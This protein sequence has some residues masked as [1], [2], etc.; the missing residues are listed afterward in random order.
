M[1]AAMWC[2][3][4]SAIPWFSSV[5]LLSTCSSAVAQSRGGPQTTAAPLLFRD[6]RLRTNQIGFHPDQLKQVMFAFEKS[7]PAP[8]GG[9]RYLLVRPDLPTQSVYEGLMSDWGIDKDS[10]E[11]VL[12]GDFSAFRIPGTY[13]VLLPD[14]ALSAPFRIAPDAN[15][16]VLR[17]A[18]RWLFLQRSGAAK[19]DALTGLRHQADYTARSPL[20]SAVGRDG[21]I[22][23]T[24]PRVD[25]SGGW[26]DAG[27]FGRYVPSAATTIMS[28]L[29]AY[30]FNPTAF[31]DRTLAIPE[32]GNGVADLLDEIRWELTWL[33]KM[34]R[35]DGAVY[36]KA[37]TRAYA[38]GMA[39]RD[40]NPAL[41]YDVS[42]QATAQ[43]AGAL[44][45]ASIVYRTIDP[46]FGARLQG[47][48]E[49]AWQ[50]LVRTPG[51]RPVGGFRNPDDPNGGD[52][53]V[54]EAD[55]GEHRLW[56]SGSLLH[57]TGQREYAEAFHRLWQRRI[58]Q[59]IYGLGW[60][61]GYAFGMFAYLDT[62][63]GDSALKQEIRQVVTTQAKNLLAVLQ[64]TAYQVVL[65]GQKSPFGYD[66][67]SVGLLLNYATYLL[68]ANQVHPDP[69]LLAGAAAQLNFV[70]GANPLG[71]VFLTGV[72]ENRVRAPHHRPSFH[73]GVALPGAVGEGPN[74]MNVGGDP[75][76]QRLF[77][78]QIPAAKR[79]VDDPESW[80]TN[81]PTIYYNAAFIAV[82]AWFARN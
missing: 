46:A 57:A 74:A 49:R 21:R 41:L 70:L 23:A 79:Y 8:T 18:S 17:L 26:W 62:S 20:R 67:G 16:E 78:A 9:L 77:D 36:H 1:L 10:D 55:E 6:D 5:F 43:F 30:R 66:W 54:K 12:R 40:P 56:A 75:A 60:P 29:Y 25:V 32:S 72:G 3:R 65:S 64:S 52:Y 11:R 47:A 53:S 27:D 28:L 39:D 15:R 42:T 45:E 51:K 48:A 37:A 34:Q 80:A 63:V 61:C 44:A 31:A 19:D 68:L 69:Q 7:E 2:S 38:P 22:A 58:D 50:F 71:K 4:R 33:L 81:E 13:Q 59:P 35:S 76:L 14:R 24:A 82:A 73:I